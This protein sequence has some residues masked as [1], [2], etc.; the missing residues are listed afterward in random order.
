M[1][2]TKN[3]ILGGV[4]ATVTVEIEALNGEVELRYLSQKEL[5]TIEE[6]ETKALGKFKTNEKANRGRRASQSQ[7]VS[8]G[9]IDIH[10]TTTAGNKAKI[11]AVKLS[12]SVPGG[13]EWTKKDVE[14]MNAKV[15]SEI[16]EK[17]REINHMGEDVSLEREVDSFHETE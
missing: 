11:E 3:E 1:V 10:A 7:L 17:V 8:E 5:N 14:D 16:Y 12:L 4:N 2:L 15:F 6:I 13:E 9:E